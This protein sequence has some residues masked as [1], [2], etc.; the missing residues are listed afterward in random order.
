MREEPKETIRQTG[1]NACFAASNSRWGFRSYYEEYFRESELDG[2]WIV[3]GGPG[4]GKSHLMRSIAE[5]ASEREWQVQTVYCSS[6]PDSLDGVILEK[7]GVKRAVLDGTAPHVREPMLAGVTSHLVDLGAFWS[8]E[9]LLHRKKEISELSQEKSKAYGRAY[10]YLSAVGETW[11]VQRELAEKYLDRERLRLSAERLARSLGDGAGAEPRNALMRSVGMKG[12]V[13]LDTWLARAE[14]VI[15]AEGAR[16]SAEAWM[17][18]VYRACLKRGLTLEV[19]KDPVLPERLEGLY[20]KEAACAVSLCPRRLCTVS[21]RVIS[22]A[23]FARRMSETDRKDYRFAERMREAL[24]GEAVHHL[25]QAGR[26]H[27]LLEE[28]YSSAMDFHAKETFGRELCEKILHL[29]N[30]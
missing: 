2:V 24:L 13:W 14:R 4:T 28:I 20:V 25:E 26:A 19:S 15:L 16:G 10:R 17:E 7:G 29:Q 18:E 11:E 5:A 22:T 30:E 9:Q 27:F 23:R 21:H 6:D 8:E 12:A 1:E 3:K